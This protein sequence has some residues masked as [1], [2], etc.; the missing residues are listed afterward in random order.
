[1]DDMTYPDKPRKQGPDS[2][3]VMEDIFTR[4][5]IV[6]TN[7]ASPFSQNRGIYG[8]SDAGQQTST[9][10]TWTR[11]VN[12]L[13]VS[14]FVFEECGESSLVSLHHRVNVAREQLV[15]IS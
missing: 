7:P 1:M 12:H 13:C 8:K 3:L 4:S 14:V 11:E 2:V 5:H 9:E 15:P 10:K 6:S